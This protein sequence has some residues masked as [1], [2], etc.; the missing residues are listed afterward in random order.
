MSELSTLVTE[1][2]FRYLAARTVQE[3]HFL[4]ELKNEARAEG[5]P[6]SGLRRNKAVSFKF[7]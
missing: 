4:R 5:I 2:H 7:S 3:D 6:R 1:E